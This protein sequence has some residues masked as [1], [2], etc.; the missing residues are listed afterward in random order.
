MLSYILV[1]YLLQVKPLTLT[2]GIVQCNAMCRNWNVLFRILLVHNSL[3]IFLVAK[4]RGYVAF[5]HA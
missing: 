1:D 3:A 2:N 5:H 4:A